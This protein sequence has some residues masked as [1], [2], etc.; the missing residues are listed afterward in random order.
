MKIAI[1]GGGPRLVCL[2]VPDTVVPHGE[3]ADQHEE[4]GYG[5]KALRDKIKE[6]GLAVQVPSEEDEIARHTLH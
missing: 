1:A 4:L 3:P 5:P 2:G 6:L